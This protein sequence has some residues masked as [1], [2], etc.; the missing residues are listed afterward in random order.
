M[1][2]LLIRP[3]TATDCLAIAAL[4][5]EAQEVLLRLAGPEVCNLAPDKTQLPELVVEFQGAL[6]DPDCD[7]LVAEQEA[8]ETRAFCAG[9][10]DVREGWF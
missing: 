5:L 8:C 3:A 9:C 10:K 2:D 1:P 6:E 4:Q 7:L